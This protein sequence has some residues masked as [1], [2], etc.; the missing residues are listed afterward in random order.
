MPHGLFGSRVAPAAIA[1]QLTRSC[2]GII[3]VDDE[4]SSCCR[5]GRARIRYV[6]DYL[7]GYNIGLVALAL[8]LR[9][10]A[11]EFLDAEGGIRTR[12]DRR[13]EKGLE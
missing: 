4:S 7:V 6:L 11:N 8:G 10:L 1:L 12:N 9:D 3:L 13:G 5:L 2:T